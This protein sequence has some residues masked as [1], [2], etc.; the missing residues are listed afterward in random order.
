MHRIFPE[1]NSFLSKKFH[2][3]R[4]GPSVVFWVPWAVCFRMCNMFFFFFFF[5]FKTM[6][7]ILRWHTKYAILCCKWCSTLLS[8][9]QGSNSEILL[10]FRSWCGNVCLC[11]WRHLQL[12]SHNSTSQLAEQ[13]NA[14]TCSQSLCTQV[15]HRDDDKPSPPEAPHNERLMKLDDVI[16]INNIHFHI[17]V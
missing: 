16:S 15:I 1:L 13:R 12:P 4:N 9:T 11:W 10:T 8:G 14:H 5:F 3:L 17:E 7:I 2:F 6:S